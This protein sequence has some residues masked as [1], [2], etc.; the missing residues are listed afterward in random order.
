[1]SGEHWIRP[2]ADDDESS[3]APE[4]VGASLVPALPPRPASQPVLPSVPPMTDEP[5]PGPPEQDHPQSSR[6]GLAVLVALG[7]GIGS[8]VI[9]ALLVRRTDSALQPAAVGVGLLVGMAVRL[10][11]GGRGRDSGAL[12]V[13]AAFFTV[14]GIAIGKYLT[15]AFTIAKTVDIPSPNPVTPPSVFSEGAL[16]TDTVRLFIEHLGLSFERLDLVWAIAAVGVA[17]LALVPPETT[18]RDQAEVRTRPPSHN[19]V[20]RVTRGLPEP[21]RVVADWV[22]TIVGA[23]AIVLIVKAFVINPYRI[24]SSSMEPTLHCAQPASGCEARFSDRVLANRFVYHLRDPRRGDIVVFKT[25]PAALSK[26]GADGTFVKRLIG[27][28]GETLEV[29]LSKGV[30]YVFI[31]G[32]KLRDPYVEKARRPIDAFGPVKI[33]KGNYFMMGDNRSA[34]CDSRQWGTVPRENI[35]GK[36]FATYWPP[37]RLHLH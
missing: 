22:V 3:S 7:V 31:N 8:G 1:V 12:H 33:A 9:W 11:G 5:V 23:I 34:S 17:L 29:R 18:T 13:V 2:P 25:P 14:L 36:V 24:P 21:M 30:G 27:L 37:N 20:D 10:T 28:P 26:C 35:I 6:L 32:K 16:S 4:D 15:F 19:P